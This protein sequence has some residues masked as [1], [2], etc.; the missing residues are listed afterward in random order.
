MA[1]CD[2]GRL[3][4][5]RNDRAE[6]PT[7]GWSGSA[8]QCRTEK[9]LLWLTPYLTLL[10]PGRT[11]AAEPFERLIGMP[12]SASEVRSLCSVHIHNC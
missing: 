4:R 10:G 5:S 7:S 6:A 8:M 2:S 3:R 12:Q 9:S 11:D 1:K